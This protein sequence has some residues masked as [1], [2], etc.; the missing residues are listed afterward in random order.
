[1]RWR[2]LQELLLA[3]AGLR[4]NEKVLAAGAQTE[5]SGEAGPVR[6]T[7][8]GWTSPAA[9]VRGSSFEDQGCQSSPR[10]ANRVQ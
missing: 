9:F 3:N 2:T 7:L 4:Y 6:N 5:R 10:S 1:M 8:G